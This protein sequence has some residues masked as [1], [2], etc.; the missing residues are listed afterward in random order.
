MLGNQLTLLAA[1]TINQPYKMA[2]WSSL[3]VTKLKIWYQVHLKTSKCKDLQLHKAVAAIPKEAKEAQEDNKLRSEDSSMQFTGGE[4]QYKVMEITQSTKM[5][6]DFWQR[7]SRISIP[8]KL[9]S[10]HRIMLITWIWHM[11]K[12]I[13][14]IEVETPAETMV[15]IS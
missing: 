11:H 15:E 14:K 6:K 2:L 8:D 4:C 12:W 5:E 13:C 10:I 3:A 1:M 9:H 7:Y